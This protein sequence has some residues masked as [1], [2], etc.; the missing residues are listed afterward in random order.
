MRTQDIKRLGPESFPLKHMP[1]SDFLGCIDQIKSL[2]SMNL[3]EFCGDYGDPFQHPDILKMIDHSISEG[4]DVEISTNGGIYSPKTFRELG[5]KYGKKLTICFSIDG[6]R[7]E[8]NERYRIGVDFDLA[9]NNMLAFN[10]VN[11]EGAFW[12]FILFSYNVEEIDDAFSLATEKG[13]KL[14][15]IVNRR[16]WKYTLEND[17]AK[18]VLEK[19]NNLSS[20]VRLKV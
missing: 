4:F 17:V 16:P 18:K 2:P 15:F 10:K 14:K 20:D 19:I 5:E 9:F 8:T 7:R 3:I 6:L 13:L 12:H 1:F 11:P